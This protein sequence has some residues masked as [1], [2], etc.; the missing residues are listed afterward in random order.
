MADVRL[1]TKTENGLQPKWHLHTVENRPCIYE[2]NQMSLF[3]KKQG[4]V[5]NNEF[6]YTE[7][8]TEYL[9]LELN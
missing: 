7:T 1:Y 5:R 8:D 6:K 3:M 9:E 2:Y 4:G